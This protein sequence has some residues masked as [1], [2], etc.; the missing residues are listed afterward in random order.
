[1]DADPKCTLKP[2]SGQTSVPGMEFKPIVVKESIFGLTG[3]G[4]SC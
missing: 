2:F 4:F 1:M 3:D